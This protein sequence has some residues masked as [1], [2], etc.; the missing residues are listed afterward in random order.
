LVATTEIEGGSVSE[1]TPRFSSNDPLFTEALVYASCLHA[2]QVRKSTD[3]P[4]VSHLLGV[5]SIAIEHGA[6]MEEAMGALLHDAAEDCGGRPRLEEIGT[7]FGR[8]VAEIVEGCT[9]TFETPK[10]DWTKRKAGYIHHLRH[11]SA[12]VRLV[13]ASDKL[14]NARSILRDFR[15]CGKQVF[16]RFRKET[17]WDVVWYYSRLAREFVKLGGGELARELARVVGE[18]EKELLAVLPT[19][20]DEAYARLDAEL[21]A[22]S[23]G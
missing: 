13:S 3:I 7:K 2:K 1:T 9:D 18:I 16:E 19:G 23:V 11:A 5:A 8:R 4:Y 10:P 6:D 15:I 12:S 22:A 21:E 20:R 14:H 17:E